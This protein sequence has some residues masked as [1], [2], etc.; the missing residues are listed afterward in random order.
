MT[1][2]AILLLVLLCCISSFAQ[3]RSETRTSTITEKVAGMQKFGGYFPF[4]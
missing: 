4:Y 1:R 3:P 2:L